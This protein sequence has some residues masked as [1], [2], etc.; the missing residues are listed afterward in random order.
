MVRRFKQRYAPMTP[1]IP[2]TKGWSVNVTI[3]PILEGFVWSQQSKPVLISPH[4]IGQV[5]IFH[6]VLSEYGNQS[7]NITHLNSCDVALLFA[8]I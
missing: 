8:I 2:L 4:Q 7:P 3:K 1:Y 6:L 5:I